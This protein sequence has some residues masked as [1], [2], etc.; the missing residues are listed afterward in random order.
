MAG[1]DSRQSQSYRQQTHSVGELYCALRTWRAGFPI[2]A[3]ATECRTHSGA[4]FA[5]P[6]STNLPRG[7]TTS[8]MGAPGI[9]L[10]S[11]ESPVVGTH[12]KTK[13]NCPP[14]FSSYGRGR[15]IPFRKRNPRHTSNSPHSVWPPSWCILILRRAIR[16]LVGCRCR[17]MMALP[18]SAPSARLAVRFMGYRGLSENDVY[19]SGSAWS[20]RLGLAAKE[21]RS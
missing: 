3:L 7:Q 2:K 14:D 1:F 21:R 6:V 15:R 17:L 5:G 18:P 4:R 20:L 9:F 11:S 8:A 12:R 13:V 19:L 10:R 16:E